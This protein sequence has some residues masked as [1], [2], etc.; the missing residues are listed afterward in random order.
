MRSSEGHPVT[1]DVQSQGYGPRYRPYRWAD[2]EF[3]LG[4]RPIKPSQWMLIDP[5]HAQTM[6]EKRTRMA[7]EPDLF[8]RTLPCSLTAQHELRERVTAHLETDFPTHFRRSGTDLRSLIDGVQF[9][10]QDRSVEPLFQM[11]SI[12]EE[13][14]MLIQ[15]VNGSWII[16]AASNAYSS[17]GR[18]VASVGRDVA[19]AHEPVPQL[20]AKLGARIDRIVSSIH[21]DT[22]CERFNWQLTPM[23]TKFFPHHAHEANAGA[24]RRICAVLAANPRQAEELLWIRVERQTLSRLPESRAVAFTLHT[25][26]DPL[27]SLKCDVDSMQ[28]ML[29]LM[30]TY[31]DA[32][33]EYSEM[34]IVRDSV[35]RWLESTAISPA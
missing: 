19:W 20:T 3:Q 27:A 1:A 9:D 16:T 11:S 10:L 34:N 15:E 18:L 7:D 17:S 12:V 14:F 24:M 30:R 22:P 13:D 8:Y 28:A 5:D 25:Y 23:S 2:A 4:L 31:S 26:S 35:I 32:R 21:D 6:R 29:R 33:L